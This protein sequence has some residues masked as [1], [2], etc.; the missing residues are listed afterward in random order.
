MAIQGGAGPI[1]L[2]AAGEPT[3]RLDGRGA[4]DAV[5]SDGEATVISGRLS[6]EPPSVVVNGQ[7]GQAVAGRDGDWRV[8]RPG[9][10]AASIVVGGQSFDF[11]GAGAQSDFAPVRAG[12]G[13]R[14]TWPTG[15][16]GRQTTWLPD[17]TP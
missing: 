11:P 4:L 9:I 12:N 5:D 16:S 2:I 7:A 8:T 3:V 13:W 15:P 14:L 6:G 1:I 10:G 17:R